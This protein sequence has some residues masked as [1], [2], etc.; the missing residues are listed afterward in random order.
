MIGISG[1]SHALYEEQPDGEYLTD[2]AMSYVDDIINDEVR[3]YASNEGTNKPLPVIKDVSKEFLKG[4]RYVYLSG[5]GNPL[6]WVTHPA[7]TT[8][9]WMER[10]YAN[11]LWR[12]FNFKKL[13]IV[14]VGGCHDAQF[15][16]TLW[17]TLK[18]SDLGDDHWYWTHGTA[19]AAC[20][21]W[22]MMLIPW[23]G[24]I[25]TI[26]GTGLTSS[27]TGDPN[28]GNGRLATDFFYMIGQY[29]AETFGEAFA[30]ATQKFIDENSI[31]RWQSHV[32]TIWNALG[33]PSLKV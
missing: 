19:G 11:N 29:G 26:G 10:I 31:G 21:C 6:V 23:G 33:D 22:K 18:S 9:E 32:L 1:L 3:C 2:L 5:H 28:T 14:V 8:D 25:A 7:D 27:L 30:G 17:T 4:A 13:P 16:I 15:N 20:F 24:A 12:L